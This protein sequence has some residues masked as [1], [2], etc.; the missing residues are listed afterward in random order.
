MNYEVTVDSAAQQEWLEALEWLY[1]NLDETTAEVLNAAIERAFQHLAQFP[2][3]GAPYQGE[4]R[5]LVLAGTPYLM[6]YALR[7]REVRILA[8]AHASRNPGYW[9]GRS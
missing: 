9:R 7:R 2:R 1:A 5:K 3:L 4:I 6:F 8:I